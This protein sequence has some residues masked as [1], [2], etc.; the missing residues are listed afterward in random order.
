MAIRSISRMQQRRGLKADL[1]ANLAEGEFGWCL[2]TQELFIGNSVGYGGNSEILTEHS[3]NGALIKNTFATMNAQISA[4]SPRSLGDKLNDIASIKDFG[5]MGD[6]N[7]DDAPAINAAI[8]EIFGTITTL[9]ASN[10][11]LYFPAG[12]YC[13]KSP[14]LLYPYVTLIGDGI[15]KTVILSINSSMTCLMQTADSSGNTGMNIGT[16]VVNYVLPTRIFVRNLSIDTNSQKIDA[17]HLDRYQ[18]VR[19]E[20]VQFIGGY[21]SADS[22][23][24]A[25]SGVRL[26]SIGNTVNTYDSQ[27]VGC[28]FTNFTYGVLA[29][30]PVMYTTISQSY[31]TNLYRGVDIGDPGAFNGPLY[32]AVT[33]TN[34]NSIDNYGIYVGSINPGVASMANTFYNCGVGGSVIY[35]APNTVCNTSVGDQFTTANGVNNQGSTLVNIILDPEQNSIFAQNATQ[36]GVISTST[37]ATYYPV[38]SST[39]SGNVSLAVN[40][41][42]EFNPFTGNLLLQG[43]STVTGNSAIGGNLVVNGNS[44]VQGNLVVAGAET[45]IQGSLNLGGTLTTDSGLTVIGA[46]TINGFVNTTQNLSIGTNTIGY[47]VANRTSLT[48]NGPSESIL[49]LYTGGSTPGGNVWYDGTNISINAQT[50]QLL[51]NTDTAQPI[52]FSTN[53]S[54][55]L[56]ITSLGNVGIGVVTP[57]GNLHVDSTQVPNVLALGGSYTSSGINFRNTSHTDGYIYYDN[58]ANLTFYTGGTA[59]TTIDQYGNLSVG[60]ATVGY[61]FGGRT[62]LTVNGSTQSIISL[63]KNNTTP[64]GFLYYDGTNI[65]LASQSGA[66]SLAALGPQSILFYT[67][68]NQRVVINS[69]GKVGIN[70]TTPAYELD[71]AG[72]VR[73]STGGFV[74]P[75]NT[76]QTTAGTWAISLPNQTG[77]FTGTMV[78]TGWQQFPSGMIMQWGYVDFGGGAGEGLYGPY[79]FPVSFPNA[80]SSLTLTTVTPEQGSDISS[81]DNQIN[82]SYSYLPTTT[83]FYVWDNSI[84]GGN[85]ANGFYWHAIGF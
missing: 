31:M 15:E 24:N 22:T 70:V 14:I 54:A 74:F 46:T 7:T 1:P 62:S 32:T 34:F 30:D 26:Q 36:V 52:T 19:F 21:I 59:K 45:S 33:L 16:G 9:G 85:H 67:N 53:N 35:W 76:T 10:V 51:L 75:D 17:V 43:N 49:A 60:T 58:L 47:P 4:A 5:A 69:D 83:Q 18:H 81:G 80:C 29:N 23:S 66:L 42:F 79:P 56:T 77:G 20:N 28:E 25:N 12:I 82:V 57:Q 3:P 8:A 27:F 71:V 50:G 61:S 64:G 63:Y 73:S 11:A 78:N 2:D 68:N 65:E 6:G 13:I 40:T 37:N 55:R 38:L 39:T 44:V 72:S 84:T 41:N 48:V